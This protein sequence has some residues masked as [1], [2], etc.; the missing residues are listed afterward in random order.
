MSDLLRLAQAMKVIEALDAQ[1][2]IRQ[3]R[4]LVQLAQVDEPM[5][6]T[7]LA[8]RTGLSVSTMSRYV[9]SF[10]PKGLGLVTNEKNPEEGRCRVVGLTRKGRSIIKALVTELETA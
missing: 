9:A 7:E 4:C 2:P 10:G 8:K 6:Q 3:A 5:H 1:M